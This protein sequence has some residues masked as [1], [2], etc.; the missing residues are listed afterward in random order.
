VVTAFR[1]DTGTRSWQVGGLQPWS[2]VVGAGPAGIAVVSEI[3]RHQ[4]HELLLVDQASERVRWRQRLPGPLGHDMNPSMDRLALVTASD[5]VLV[6]PGPRGQNPTSLAARAQDGRVRWRIPMQLAGW[7]TWTPDGRLLVV[8]APAGSTGPQQSLLAVDVRDGRLLWRS[9]LPLNA[10][11][12]AAL[13]GAG[14]VIQ[15]WDPDPVHAC[16]AVGT[17]SGADGAPPLHW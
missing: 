5:V 17:A 9:P 12:P 13:L 10:D 2:A 1:L 15:V 4:R 3:D 16:A 6:T 7:P 11:R 14:A 8:G